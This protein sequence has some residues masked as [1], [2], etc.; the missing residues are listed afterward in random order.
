MKTKQR[1]K[2]FK[3]IYLY[4]KHVMIS[5]NMQKK[6]KK[7]HYK[8]EIHIVIFACTFYSE[9]IHCEI[10]LEILV[11]EHRLICIRLNSIQK[12][13]LPFPKPWLP[14]VIHNNSL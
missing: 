10:Y 4:Y 1:V 13:D 11:Y 5:F 2:T 8:D 7:G 14:F 12:M 9:K 6:S 3:E